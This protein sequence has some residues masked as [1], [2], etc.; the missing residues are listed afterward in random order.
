MP[1][2]NPADL[3]AWLFNPIFQTLF[4]G[5]AAGYQLFGDIG[6]AIIVLTLVI[7][8]VLIPLTRQQI[9]SQRRMQ[10]IQPEIKAIQTRYKG[11]RTKINEETMK[12][13]RERGSTRPRD[14]C[15]P[16]SSCSC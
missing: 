14:V 13:Y 1:S 11:N 15:R 8:T 6:I 10:M 9:V 16:S 12:L 3:L 7:K 5:L 2:G 4:L